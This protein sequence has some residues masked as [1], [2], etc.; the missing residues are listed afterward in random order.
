VARVVIRIVDAVV[1][2]D[3]Q[4]SDRI[5]L[6]S[7]ANELRFSDGI[8][9]VKDWDIESDWR[10]LD[11]KILIVIDRALFEWIIT[12]DPAEYNI[13]LLEC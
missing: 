7:A 6:W 2:L 9:L 4:H 1:G 10:S 5:L 8:R 13:F 11:L 12:V 3:D